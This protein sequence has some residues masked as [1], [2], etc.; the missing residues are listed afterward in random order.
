MYFE[1]NTSESHRDN[2]YFV[3]LFSGGAP[4]TL[5]LRNEMKNNLAVIYMKLHF[6]F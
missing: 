6:A 4:L 5:S 3:V 2:D 1:L